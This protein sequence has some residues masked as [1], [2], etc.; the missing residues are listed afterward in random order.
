MGS[1]LARLTSLTEFEPYMNSDAACLA[2]F[3]QLKK[4]TLKCVVDP[5][6]LISA[7]TKCTLLHT[8]D[9]GHNKITATQLATLLTGLP[10]LH[11]LTLYD[12]KSLHSLDFISSVSHLQR[13]LKMIEIRECNAI[14][15][16]ELRHLRLLSALETLTLANSFVDQLD[17]ATIAS[18]N[19]ASRAFLR[20]VWPNL[21]S[22][23]Y[24]W[25]IRARARV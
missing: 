1:V 2:S 9:L 20:D 23:D 25:N 12:M 18:M 4:A 13:T 8:L 19:P 5:S 17:K 16:D 21:V 14:P 3:T 22:L 10:S 15:M 11:T 24:C 6:Q 7:L